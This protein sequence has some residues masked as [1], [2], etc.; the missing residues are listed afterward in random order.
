MKKVFLIATL[1]ALF[2]GSSVNA[3]GLK[4]VWFGGGT[5]SL[6]SERTIESQGERVKEFTILPMFGKF[7]TPSVAVGGAAGFSQA[8]NSTFKEQNFI[9]QPLVRK[10]WNISGKLYAF[11]QAALPV[12][13]G[14]L[15]ENGDKIA[16]SFGINFAFAPGLDLIVT[17]WLSIE[18][19]FNLVGLSF[20]SYNPKEDGADRINNFSFK[21]DGLTSTKFGNINVGVK[22]LF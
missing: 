15:K 9:I 4:G 3:Q 18:A 17:N 11:T 7:I 19:S 13:F 21:G 6:S 12:T 2:I 20:T 5:L 1:V 10:Y 8:D 14:N 16:N 22:I